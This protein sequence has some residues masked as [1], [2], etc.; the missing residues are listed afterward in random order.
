MTGAGIGPKKD[1]PFE[2]VKA[3]Y[4]RLTVTVNNPGGTPDGE[5]VIAEFQLFDQ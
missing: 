4:F 2:P 3:R 5:P 1:L